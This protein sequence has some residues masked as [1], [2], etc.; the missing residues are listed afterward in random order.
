MIVPVSIVIPIQNEADTLPELL[1]SLKRQTVMPEEVIFA[2]ANS[3]DGG[4]FLIQS[5]WMSN[6]WEGGNFRILP[7]PG[8]FP[9][10]GRNVGIE[11]A[12]GEWIAFLDAG[13]SAHPNWLSGLLTYVKDHKMEAVFGVGRFSG[14]G[15]VGRAVCALSYGERAVRAILP[16]SLF[17]REVFQ[18]VGLFSPDLRMHEDTQ[19]VARYMK[20]YNLKNGEKPVNEK[21]LVEY[22]HFPSSFARALW[23]WFRSGTDAVRAGVLK[24]QQALYGGAFLI[25]LA[26][27]LFFNI[28]TALL[29]L[30]GGC[31][32][33]RGCI[34]PMTRSNPWHW[35]RGES[36]AP[37]AVLLLSLVMD[38]A[39]GAG[40][41][42]GYAVK[43]NEW[44]WK[45]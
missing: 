19:W 8:R 42:W 27:T 21:A 45:G 18:K 15:T 25:G 39:K 23:K 33:I 41:L 34:L 2:D 6:A 10:A 17:H 43:A 38:L 30:F 37:A 16:A 28:E 13:I 31:I 35:W 44:R 14:H 20:V 32:M 9:G 29:F 3:T 36:H 4:P 26:V 1:A 5:W 11:A 12:K 7:N 40:F 24:R 22:S